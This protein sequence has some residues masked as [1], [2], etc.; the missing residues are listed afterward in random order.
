MVFFSV[1]C[2]LFLE[3]LFLKF[4]LNLGK[5]AFQWK[6]ILLNADSL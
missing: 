1:V 5:L 2:S 6:W 4:G 3:G